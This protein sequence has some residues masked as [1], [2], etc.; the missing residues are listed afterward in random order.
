[1]AGTAV[2]LVMTVINPPVT[3]PEG[4]ALAG[5]TADRLPGAFPPG[6]RAF[7]PGWRVQE[8]STP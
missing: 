5:A 2:S 7:R 4:I 3:G 8:G 6:W 1:M